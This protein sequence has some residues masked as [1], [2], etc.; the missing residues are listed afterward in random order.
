M[1]I[2]API[3]DGIL[4]FDFKAEAAMAKYLVDRLGRE[5]LLRS[6]T[7]SELKVRARVISVGNNAILGS[8][9]C[10]SQRFVKSRT[11]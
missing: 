7:R 11:R 10:R 9:S 2:T 1:R 4:S 5:A 8:A 3:Q 6:I